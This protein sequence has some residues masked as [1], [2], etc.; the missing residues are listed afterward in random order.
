[1]KKVLSLSKIL[2]PAVILLFVLYFLFLRDLLLSEDQK[3]TVKL[4][5]YPSQFTITYIP[6]G[7][8]D[9]PQLVRSE[10]WYY[11]S[12]E[13]EISFL[14]GNFVSEEEY[15]PQGDNSETPLRPEDFDYFTNF[16]DMKSMFGTEN[17]VPIDFLPVFY[18]EGEIATY[19]TDLALFVIEK[20]R[21]TYFQTLGSGTEDF[22]ELG[23]VPEEEIEEKEIK[24]E[25]KEEEKEDPISTENWKL[26]QNSMLGIKMKYPPEWYLLDEDIVLT[27]YDTGYMEKGLELPEKRLKCDFNRFN[28]E[29]LSL[30]DEREI[31][32]NGVKISKGAAVDNSGEDG[33]GMGD[34]VMFLFEKEDFSP[35]TLVCFSYSS[36]FEEKLYKSF[37]TFEF[38]E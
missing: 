5:G 10:V 18:E 30:D 23:D 13:V 4:F 7:D 25:T 20:D 28:P 29:F 21:L 9:N 27:T 26:Y 24:E 15:T 3:N 22:L 1:M 31:I 8:A 17:I 38:I 2:I 14:G 6:R 36:D 32:D 11:N 35:I 37:E 19:L 34:A 16:N 12:Q 33:P